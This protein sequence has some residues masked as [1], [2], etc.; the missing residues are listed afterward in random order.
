MAL[1]KD[2]QKQAHIDQNDFIGKSSGTQKSR[3]ALSNPQPPSDQWKELFKN[4]PNRFKLK[5]FFLVERHCKRRGLIIT[6]NGFEIYKEGTEKFIN[7]QIEDIMDCYQKEIE[8]INRPFFTE[9]N[10]FEKAVSIACNNRI[11]SFYREYYLQNQ[12]S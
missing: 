8:E 12:D 6:S 2:D 4:L 11:N 1:K 9:P 3:K 5:L 10:G 7:D